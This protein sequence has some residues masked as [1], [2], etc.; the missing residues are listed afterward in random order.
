MVPVKLSEFRSFMEE[1]YMDASQRKE[2]WNLFRTLVIKIL[3]DEIL[4]KELIKEVRDEIQHD[5]ETFV[6]NSCKKVYSELI[7]TGP[8]QTS[9]NSENTMTDLHDHVNKL[10]K[11]EPI[12]KS[13]ERLCVMGALMH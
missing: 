7:M 4:L 2:S 5:S 1:F 13:K 3:V 12:I 6:I 11:Q 8:F 10:K 9:L